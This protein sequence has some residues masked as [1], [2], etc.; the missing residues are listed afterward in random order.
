MS[1]ATFNPPD[2]LRQIARWVGWK[3]EVRK[4]KLTK[5][6]YRIDGKGKDNAKANDPATWTDFDTA[7][8]AIDRFDGTDT[9]GMIWDAIERR[10]SDRT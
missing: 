7:V 5:V 8:A 4:N 1:S 9:A 10:L 2:A 6:P 3:S